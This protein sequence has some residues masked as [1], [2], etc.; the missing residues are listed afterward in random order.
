LPGLVLGKATVHTLLSDVVRADMAAEIG[1][2]N[3]DIAGQ[4]VADGFGGQRLPDLVGEHEGRLV[5]AI[6]IA[7]QLQR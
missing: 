7:A 5:L 6:Q 1:A 3:L 4:L 2:I